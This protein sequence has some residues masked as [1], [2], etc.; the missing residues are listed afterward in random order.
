MSESEIIEFEGK[1]FK[2]TGEFRRPMEGEFYLGFS[3][4]L[5]ASMD[6][7]HLESA[8]YILRELPA[9]P[10]SNPVQEVRKMREIFKGMTVTEEQLRELRGDEQP[11]PAAQPGEAIRNLSW[12]IWDIFHEG[13]FRS[14]EDVAAILTERIATLLEKAQAAENQLTEYLLHDMTGNVSASCAHE[15]LRIELALWQAKEKS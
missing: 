15:N 5:R 14:S 8:Q 6:F 13:K 2:K 11:K 4:P 10:A 9:E 12:T 1:R 3:M 7:N